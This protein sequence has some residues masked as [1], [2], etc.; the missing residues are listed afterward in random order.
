MKASMILSVGAAALVSAQTGY[1][2]STVY[3]THVYTVTSCAPTV[4]NCPARSGKP[5]VT[6]DIISLYTTFCPV[7]ATETSP[8]KY[9]TGPAGPYPTYPAGTGGNGGHPAP[10]PSSAPAP[11]AAPSSVPGGS[12]PSQAAPPAVP[13]SVLG[14]AGSSQAAPPP[15][16]TPIL[17]TITITS[18]VPTTYTSVITVVPSGTPAGAAA[19]S[20]TGSIPKPYT[21]STVPFTGGASA[22]KA[23]GL[24]MVAGLF[25]VLL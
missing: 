4:T 17:S 16:N 15:S 2:V 10:P 25:A 5:Y 3:S 22:Q 20:G 24:L 12:A 13:S 14:G 6:T 19:P 11:P 9:P 21:N 8:P 1:T 18:C 7:A 23:G